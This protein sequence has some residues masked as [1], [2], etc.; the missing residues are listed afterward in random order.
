MG[1]VLR[2]VVIMPNQLK[3]DRRRVSYV[4][5]IELAV[6]LRKYAEL[7]GMTINDVVEGLIHQEV[8]DIELTAEEILAIAQEV[9]ENER[10]RRK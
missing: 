5:P 2:E 8:K 7:R 9:K 3:A 4:L 6:R 1:A 10:K